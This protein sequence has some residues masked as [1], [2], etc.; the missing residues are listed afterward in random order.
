MH[1]PDGRYCATN[2]TIYWECIQ[3][4]YGLQ[5]RTNLLNTFVS[6]LNGNIEPAGLSTN[7]IQQLS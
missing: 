3:H 1:K 6:E 7:A 5:Q 4:Q 2:G